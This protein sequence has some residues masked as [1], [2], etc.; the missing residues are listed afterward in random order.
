M[1]VKAVKS[2]VLQT[3][4]IAHNLSNDLFISNNIITRLSNR[5]PPS[6][7]QVNLI[8]MALAINSNFEVV[9]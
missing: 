6:R 4:R 2:N 5:N 7:I 8:S 9:K 1:F 3:S